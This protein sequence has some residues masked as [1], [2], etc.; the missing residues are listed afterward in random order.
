[1]AGAGSRRCLCPSALLSVSMLGFNRP[2]AF[3][4]V[5]IRWNWSGKS[6]SRAR[7]FPSA[8]MLAITRLAAFGGVFIGRIGSWG[9]ACGFPSVLRLDRLALFRGVGSGSGGGCCRE[10]SK[11][12]RDKAKGG[13]TLQALHRPSL[14]FN[15]TYIPVVLD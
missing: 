3:A 10:V 14:Q 7:C 12:G 9:G 11:S 1:M 8:D 4:D 13:L 2:G 15:V 6:G 5:F